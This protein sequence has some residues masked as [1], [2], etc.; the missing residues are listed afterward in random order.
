MVRDLTNRKIGR[1]EAEAG[2]DGYR[3]ARGVELIFRG[4]ASNIEGVP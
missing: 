1:L 4:P 3:K 2:S